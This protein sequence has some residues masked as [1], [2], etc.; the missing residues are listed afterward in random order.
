MKKNWGRE[1][2]KREGTRGYKEELEGK[3]NYRH[4]KLETIRR[5]NRMGEIKRRRK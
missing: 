1:E 2:I 4:G 3:T 5:E